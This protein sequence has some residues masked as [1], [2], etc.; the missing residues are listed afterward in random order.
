MDVTSPRAM[1]FGSSLIVSVYK[2]AKNLECILGCLTRQTTKDFEV[3]IS[4]DGSSEEIKS[5]LKC[6]AATALDLQHLT[7]EDLGF[8]KN[9]AL[10]Q[11]IRASRSNHLIFIDGDCVP[12]N[13]FIEAHF[14]S[15]ED[16]SISA[17]RRVELGP[18]WS[19]RLRK[20]PRLID[21]LSSNLGYIFAAPS[22]WLDHCKNYES[23]FRSSILQRLH[24]RGHLDLVG[25]NFSCS[26]SALEEINGFNEDYEAPGLGEDTDPQWRLEAHGYRMTN[27]KFLAPLFHLYHPRSYGYSARNEEIFL[28][29]RKLGLSICEAGLYRRGLG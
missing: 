24:P 28:T 12:P 10:N 6:S 21:R 22:L 18:G 9:K 26:K 8:R 11:A 14:A 25:C 4:E 20:D 13:A 17:G 5:A 2:D 3:I 16:R 1:P 7:Q 19:E 27:I 15:R 29:N 23:G